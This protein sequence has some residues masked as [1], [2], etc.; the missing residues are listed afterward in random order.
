MLQLRDGLARTLEI[1]FLAVERQ[2]LLV[3]FVHARMVNAC[4]DSAMK[5]PC[6]GPFSDQ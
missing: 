1:T 5:N 3:K 4:C 6:F 2:N